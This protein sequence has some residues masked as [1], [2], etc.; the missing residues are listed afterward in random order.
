[1]GKDDKRQYCQICNPELSFLFKPARGTK[2]V[3]WYYVNVPA[4]PE[5]PTSEKVLVCKTCAESVEK[6]FKVNYFNR[7]G[8]YNHAW[9][10]TN[11]VTL[12]DMTDEWECQ[13]CGVTERTTIGR[14]TDEGCPQPDED[15]QI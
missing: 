9:E 7:P 1:M 8:Q 15:G 10:K 4:G 3:G 2:A 5:H 6:Y 14:P 12:E 11:L 13:K